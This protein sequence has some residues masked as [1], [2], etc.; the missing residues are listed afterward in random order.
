MAIIEVQ[1]PASTS[2]GGCFTDLEKILKQKT[3]T[4]RAIVDMINIFS[5]LHIFF[6]VCLLGVICG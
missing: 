2:E 5:F 1:Q 3:F 4:R 6:G